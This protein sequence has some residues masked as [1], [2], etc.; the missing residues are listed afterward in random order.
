[1][2]PPEKIQPRGLADYL[3]VMSKGVFQSGMSWRVVEAKWPGIREAFRGFEPEAVAH[4]TPTDLDELATDRRVIRNRRKLE[5]IVEN[6]Q[7]M[8]ELE[9]RWGTFAGYLRSHS[10]FEETVARPAKALPLSRRPGRLPLSLGGERG[11]A[12]LRRVVRLQRQDSQFYRLTTISWTAKR[13]DSRP[14][15]RA[16]GRER[17]T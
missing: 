8:L 17:P 11:G 3:D 16:Y 4:L 15:W 7:R 13:R 14:G 2:Q 1:M 6:A 12:L 5:A 9:E 10:G